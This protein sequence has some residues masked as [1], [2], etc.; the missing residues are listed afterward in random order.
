MLR[1][2]SGRGDSEPRNDTGN[3]YSCPAARFR[4]SAL[5][6]DV[7]TGLQVQAMEKVQL[8]ELASW[9]APLAARYPEVRVRTVAVQQDPARALLREGAHAQLIVVGSRGRGGFRGL[10][11]GSV[12]TDLLREAKAPLAIVRH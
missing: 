9:V 12:G 6:S 5:R 2:S 10:L 11:L 8:A 1:E 7:H 3:Y 4:R